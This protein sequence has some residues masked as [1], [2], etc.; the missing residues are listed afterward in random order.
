[1]ARVLWRDAQG[2]EGTVVLSRQE[3][4]IGRAA[5]CEICTEDGMVSRYHARIYRKAAAYLIEDLG[6][7]NGIF[8]EERQV[9]QHVLGHGDAVRCGSLWIRFIDASPNAI[10]PAEPARGVRGTMVLQPPERPNA[11][12]GGLAPTKSNTTGSPTETLPPPREQAQD[13]QHAVAPSVPQGPASY[14]APSMEGEASTRADQ[15]IR[16][17]RRRID[18]LQLELRTLRGPKIG[19]QKA[20]TIEAIEGELFAVVA[21]RDDLREQ[22][23]QLTNELRANSKDRELARATRV[24]EA[25]AIASDTL[26]DSLASLR[27]ELIAASDEFDQFSA[28]VPRASFELIRQSLRDASRHAET[29]RAAVRAL[30]TLGDRGDSVLDES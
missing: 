2:K 30:A 17:L 22:V 23:M 25:A 14:T 21:Q 4:R 7:A 29:A 15:E 10:A 5:D 18:Q 19:E 11:A 28:D 1:M 9:K 8:F 3:V 12:S 27:V 26:Q 16:L 20:A 24:I 13:G 6:S